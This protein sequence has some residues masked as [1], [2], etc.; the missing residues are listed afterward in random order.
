MAELKNDML[1][2]KIS[3]HGAEIKSVKNIKTGYEY[4]WQAD[5]SFWGRTSPVLFPVVGQYRDKESIYKGVTYTMGQHGFA[6]DMD[7]TFIDE[8]ASE[9]SKYGDD[10]ALFLLKDNPETHKKYP[11]GFELYIRYVLSGNEIKVVWTVKNTN[12]ET[13]HFSIGAHPAFNCDSDKDILIF[14]TDKA[15]IAEVLNE[16]GVLS[17][18]SKEIELSNRKLS[19]SAELFSEDAL[20]LEHGQTKEIS[21][22]KPDGR[23]LVTVRF[24]SE[25]VGIWSPVGKHAPFVC[26]EPWYGRA[27]RCDFNKELTEREYGNVLPAGE[28]FE[29]SYTMVFHG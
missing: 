29:R 7:F 10:T 8:D 15:L 9:K 1:S 14:D 11:F 26:I 28:T 2:V 24:E 23:L 5:P 4:M 20:I 17:G 21:V 18:R 19:M 3:E 27:D 22:A 13:M 16:N 25:L 6:R 12:D